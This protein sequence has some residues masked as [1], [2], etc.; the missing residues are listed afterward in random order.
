AEMSPCAMFTMAQAFL[1]T[2]SARMTGTGWRS[3]PMG[4]LMIDRWV[5]APQYLSAGTSSGPK[6]S[7][8]VRV[9]GRIAV[10]GR[11]PRDACAPHSGGG[12]GNQSAYR[13]IPAR[14]RRSRNRA[15]G[16]DKREGAFS[17]PAE[18]VDPG[19]RQVGPDLEALVHRQPQ[20]GDLLGWQRRA[21]A[22]GELHEAAAG[23]EDVEGGGNDALAHRIRHR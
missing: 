3:Q 10:I 22:V 4:K 11:T 18:A 15:A 12:R 14:G 19:R 16:R 6:L 21:G 13:R 9:S 23:G 1:I 5:C 17:A 2:P 8:S 20:G 7:V